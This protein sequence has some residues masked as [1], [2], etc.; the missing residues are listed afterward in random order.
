VV[1][2]AD[3]AVAAALNTLVGDLLAQRQEARARR[4][5]AVADAVRDR[6]TAAGVTVE[7]SP[8]GP[9]WTLKDT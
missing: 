2:G 9:T 7:D 1:T 4:D 3:E 8:D 6:L 5:F